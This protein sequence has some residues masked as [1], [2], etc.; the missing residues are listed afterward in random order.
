MVGY[1]GSGCL[2]LLGICS[3][4]DCGIGCVKLLFAVFER[5]VVCVLVTWSCVGVCWFGF[6]WFDV[7]V[8]FD[9][10]GIGFTV[11]IVVW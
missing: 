5:V 4:F 6:V 9:C 10:L 8:M 1:A 11:A 3:G 2:G 7:C